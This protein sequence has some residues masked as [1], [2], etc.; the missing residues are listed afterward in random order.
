MSARDIAH[1]IQE[2]EGWTDSTLLDVLLDYIDNQ[3]SDDAFQDYL[4]DRT[5]YV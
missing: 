4:E 1:D 3:A 5:V 2:R